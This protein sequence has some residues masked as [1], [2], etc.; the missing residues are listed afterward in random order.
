MYLWPTSLRPRPVW[1]VGDRRYRPPQAS[2]ECW[3]GLRKL[4]PPFLDHD[5]FGLRDT[6]LQLLESGKS[7]CNL[8]GAPLNAKVEIHIDQTLESTWR[9][10]RLRCARS[11]AL[12]QVCS[13]RYPRW[14]CPRLCSRLMVLRP[15]PS[16]RAFSLIHCL[17]F[18][19]L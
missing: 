3:T 4:F 13:A 7:Y 18:K 19:R 9:A 5:T 10:L 11:D 1:A 8:L 6:P 16:N 2:R 12:A 15:L 14:P 17:A